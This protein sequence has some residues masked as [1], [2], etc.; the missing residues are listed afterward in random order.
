MSKRT[1]KQILTDLQNTL[2]TAKYGLDDLLNGDPN[3]RISG[4]RNLIVFGRA[5]TNVL[6]NLRS[7][8]KS[9][10]EWYT[11]YQ[12]EMKNDQVMRYFY[13]LRSEILKKGVLNTGSAVHLSN[14]NLN[15]IHKFG[16]PPK[17]ARRF[18]FGDNIGGSGWEIE[19]PDGT[20]EKYYASIP[21]DVGITVQL[22]FPEPPGILSN[23]ISDLL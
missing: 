6:Q 22:I 14:F 5:V 4:L 17:N 20:L 16:P 2:E 1:T 15:E 21:G 10:D 23:D 8:E 13:K 18:F 7:T 3:R 12:E 11:P 19:L 9:F